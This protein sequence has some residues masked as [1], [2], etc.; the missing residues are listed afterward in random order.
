MEHDYYSHYV[1]TENGR[2]L[3]GLL[4]LH[5]SNM[6]IHACFNVQTIKCCVYALWFRL[7]ILPGQRYIRTLFERISVEWC[8]ICKT[9]FYSEND[10]G[11]FQHRWVTMQ[12]FENVGILN[13]DENSL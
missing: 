10:G 11:P 8:K 9:L 5:T 1:L 13:G 4:P 7:C 6:A 2:V 3:L 12:T